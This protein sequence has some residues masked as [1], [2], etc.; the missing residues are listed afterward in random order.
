MRIQRPGA[1]MM[2]F[3]L[4]G[5]IF[6]ASPVR[7][8]TDSRYSTLV[9]EALLR[10]GSLA[11]DP[12]FPDRAHLPY[13][14]ETV[15]DHV[16][17]WYPV[18]GPILAT[19]LVWLLDRVGVSAV[20]PSGAYEAGGDVSVQG[21]LATFFM[22]LV[23]S[24]FFAS[25]RAIFSRPSAVPA[26]TRWSWIV[27]LGGA[28]GTQVWTTASRVLWG[29]T[30]LVLILGVVVWLLVMSEVGRRR[31][32]ALWLGTLLAWSYFV[33]PTASVSIVAVTIYVAVTERR[34]L[35]ALLATGAVWLALFLVYSRL[36]FGIWLPTYYRMTTFSMRTFG[37]GLLG[38]LVSPS[39]G[40]LV[41]VPVTA[42][43]LYVVVRYRRALP[44]AR[45]AATA[46]GALVC[47]V[48]LI[49]AFEN[50]HGGHSYGPR[51]L[52]PV[53]PWLVLVAALG[54]RALLDERARGMSYEVT[55]GAVLLSCSVL[56]QARG[57]WARETWTWNAEPTNVS[58]HVE[59]VWSWRHS[60]PLAGLVR[61]PLPTVITPLPVGVRLDL[62]SPE[63]QPYL[64]SGWSGS[65]GTFRWTDGRS[66]EL[67]FGLTA[68]E[69]LVLEIEVEGFLPIRRGV[70]EQRVQIDLNGTRLEIARVNQRG[71]VQ[72]ALPLPQSLLAP[73][74]RL[75]F[76]LPDA[77]FAAVFGLG[78]DPR[79][80]A[81]KVHGLRLR[82]AS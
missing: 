53:V 29:D 50:W 27:A 78:Q 46:L 36:T 15:G 37:S 17:S 54:L 34:K 25:A 23:A 64:L 28:L 67:V 40:Q 35:P 57:A 65:E 63:A 66:A 81:L 44:H 21:T 79:Q 75:L 31:L 69:P 38:I 32:S 52:T 47:H 8:V 39:R 77:A 5:A 2:I 16:Y 11:L 45:L 9:S 71:L 74:N 42:F 82:S 19:P 41:F 73:T 7:V 60:Q 80:L 76:R 55:A 72:L 24:L 58:D 6:L 4:T 22:A 26:A 30:F 43:V 20:G 56:L 49:A 48:A 68:I 70:T 18:G 12:W 3:L 10:H 14:V 1:G 13:Q 59:R 61:P 33:R 51:Y 62:G